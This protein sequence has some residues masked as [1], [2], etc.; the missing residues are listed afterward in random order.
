MVSGLAEDPCGGL[1]VSYIADGTYVHRANG[2]LFLP[3][4]A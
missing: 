2:E 1:H 4:I 3:L